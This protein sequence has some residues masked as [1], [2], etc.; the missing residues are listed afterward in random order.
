MTGVK[1]ERLDRLLSRLGYGSRSDVQAWLRQGLI[2]VAGTP[3]RSP[4]LKVSPD[5]VLIDGKPMDHPYGLTVIYHKPLDAVCSHRETGRLIYDDFPERWACRKPAL[6][7]VGRLDKETSGLLIVT[8]DGQLN[9]RITSPKH[10]IS[11][12]YVATLHAPLAGDEAEVFAS[13]KLLLKDDDKPCLPAE[14]TVI[15]ET[16]VSIVLHEGRYHQVRRM[17]AAVGNHVTE[18]TRSHIGALSL[19]STALAPGEYRSTTPDA[20]LRLISGTTQV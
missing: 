2:T 20:L 9:H 12:T 10:H 8:D 16:H 14:L 5:D 15:D 4:S 6:S 1:T 3:A 11:R 18:L 7:S 19:A 13:G 17:F